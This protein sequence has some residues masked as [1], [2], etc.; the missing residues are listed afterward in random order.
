MTLEE[1]DAEIVQLETDRATV[2]AA[3]AELAE[4]ELGSRLLRCRIEAELRAGGMN[5]TESE[6]E[7]KIAP[8]YIDYEKHSIALTQSCAIKEAVAECRRLRIL[9][10][11]SAEMSV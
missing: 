5:K 1:L 8:E 9:S 7:A 2:A 11:I 6:R 4:R 3:R 10:V